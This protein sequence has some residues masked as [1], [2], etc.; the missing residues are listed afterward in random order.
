VDIFGG[1]PTATPADWMAAATQ[2]KALKEVALAK[3]GEQEDVS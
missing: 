2:E 1:S 3:E